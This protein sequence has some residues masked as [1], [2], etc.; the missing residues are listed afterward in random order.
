MTHLSN[1][2]LEGTELTKGRA[3]AGW[4]PGTGW[5]RLG[6]SGWLAA[7]IVTRDWEGC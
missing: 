4:R 3:G 6:W 2:H 1:T 5:R 7:A